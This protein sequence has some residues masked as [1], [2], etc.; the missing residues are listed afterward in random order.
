MWAQLRRLRPTSQPQGETFF[1]WL[2]TREGQSHRAWSSASHDCRGPLS[3]ST[4]RGGRTALVLPSHPAPPGQ[5]GPALQLGAEQL[6]AQDVG[7]LND[8]E[9]LRLWKSPGLGS[10]PG[11]AGSPYCPGHLPALHLTPA[12]AL[13]SG[14]S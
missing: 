2:T 4:V 14:T 6:L 5:G 9:Q 12:H 13:A 3:R 7:T 10:V 11:P 1:C 8:C